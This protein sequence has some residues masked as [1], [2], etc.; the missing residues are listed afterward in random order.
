LG[1]LD[2]EQ[3]VRRSVERPR[4]FVQ[5]GWPAGLA[6]FDLVNRLLARADGLRQIGLRQT[7]SLAK[8]PNPFRQNGICHAGQLTSLLVPGL[9]RESC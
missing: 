8:F 1:F 3:I 6:A 7:A 2:A 9:N 4:Q 5:S